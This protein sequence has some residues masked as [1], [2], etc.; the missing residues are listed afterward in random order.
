METTQGLGALGFRGFSCQV[1][2]N[3][4]EGGLGSIRE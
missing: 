1:A 3:S 2:G 4:R